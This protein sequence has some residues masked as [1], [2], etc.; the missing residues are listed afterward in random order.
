MI[1]HIWLREKKERLSH[2]GIIGDLSIEW[3]NLCN[4][5][6]FR[7]TLLVIIQ[8]P[9]SAGGNIMNTSSFLAYVSLIGISDFIFIYWDFR[10]DVFI[11]LFTLLISSIILRKGE[12]LFGK[13]NYIYCKRISSDELNLS[14][15]MSII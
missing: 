4:A 6:L 12:R 5:K 13:S 8:A 9:A 2:L 10:F 15:F 14:G 11:Y 1:H 3:I 7:T